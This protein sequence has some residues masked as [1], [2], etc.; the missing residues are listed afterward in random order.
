MKIIKIILI[1]VI[2]VNLFSFSA[3]ENKKETAS[4]TSSE[5]QDASNENKTIMLLS[6]PIVEEMF[7]Q[8]YSE[9]KIYYDVADD[10]DSNCSYYL[11][12]K[13]ENFWKDLY[14]FVSEIKVEPIEKYDIDRG[15]SINFPSLFSVNGKDQIE[16]DDNH[17]RAYYSEGI[18]E[19]IKTFI[20]P[21]IAEL[22]KH[23]TVSWGQD[24]F[25]FEYK[26]FDKN[27][28]VIDSDVISE[29]PNIFI[30]DNIAHMWI[31]WGTGTLTRTGV[32]YDIES[33]KKSPVY[34]GQTDH[35]GTVV[36]CAE[37]DKVSLYDMFSGKTL[38]VIDEF[39][40]PIEDALDGV[41]RAEFSKD[42]KQIIVSCYPYSKTENQ[43]FDIPE[44]LFKQ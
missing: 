38:Y 22:K 23:Y 5:I 29:E 35:Y 21:Y 31:Q 9:L 4:V 37:Y 11:N 8:N 25:V 26:I 27:G 42:G 17:D 18:Y 40:L 24:D 20:K 10:P 2:I 30:N 44:N 12:S 13:N 36:C 16:V 32:F 1:I 33:G 3:C 43:V 15:N 41:S 19:R 39:D 28:R 14:T 6:D 7:N 34:N